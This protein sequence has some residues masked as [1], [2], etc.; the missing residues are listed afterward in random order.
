MEG[1]S[2]EGPRH[3]LG[4]GGEA[5]LEETAIAGDGG[6]E[7]E[8]CRG[9]ISDLCRRN[10]AQGVAQQP[11]VLSNRQDTAQRDASRHQRGP[12]F[13]VARGDRS[14]LEVIAGAYEPAV[15]D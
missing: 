6:G 1:L 13:R 8:N 15:V 4:A 2:A 9:R 5:R 14:F 7:L 12:D 11:T 10:A 3:Q